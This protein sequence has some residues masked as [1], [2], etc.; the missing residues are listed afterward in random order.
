MMRLSLAWILLSMST[1]IWADAKDT[2]IP[3]MGVLVAAN[4]EYDHLEAEVI[5]LERL[6]KDSRERGTSL[7]ELERIGEDLA[8]AIHRIE[9]LRAELEGLYVAA[10][11]KG[12]DDIEIEVKERPALT[13]R[14][15]R[16]VAEEPEKRGALARADRAG[17]KDGEAQ[18]TLLE[19]AYSEFQKNETSLRARKIYENLASLLADR[20]KDWKEGMEVRAVAHFRNVAFFRRGLKGDELIT[21]LSDLEADC[22]NS[23][24]G[25]ISMLESQFLSLSIQQI[26]ALIRQRTFPAY[27]YRPEF[28][29]KTGE[30]SYDKGGD[31][32]LEM[33]VTDA[34]KV[35]RKD[36]NGAMLIA[37]ESG[38]LTWCGCSAPAL[39]SLQGIIDS[40]LF[41][42]LKNRSIEVCP[43]DWP[44]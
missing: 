31:F 37:Q 20:I 14:P 42:D 6:L 12:L 44:P 21:D 38:D 33:F 1:L 8:E 18:K 36:I 19:D 40:G 34:T 23:V 11:L 32:D 24:E 43:N 30:I 27:P 25:V 16:Q 41:R 26:E 35:V 28:N 15:R 7:S 39:T 4:L 13:Q 10:E 22:S 3:S 9:S 17:A 29:H 2:D 5:R